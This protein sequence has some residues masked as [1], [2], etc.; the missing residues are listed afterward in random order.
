M[1]SV[2]R[3]VSGFALAGLFPLL[4]VAQTVPQPTAS[5][6][7][8]SVAPS[9]APVMKATWWV[10]NPDKTALL[11]EQTPISFS[12]ERPTQPSILVDTTQ[13]FQTMD[14]FGF[15]LTGGSA[16][17]IQGLEPSVRKALLEELFSTKG[18]GIG[19][20]YLRISIGSSDLDPA[21]FTYDD[22]PKGQTDPEL[23]QF[24][25][26]KDEQ[27]LIPLLHEVLAINPRIHIL[28]SP[29]SAPSWMKD[30]DTT[31]A[32]HLDPQWYKA[33][34]AYLVKYIKAMRARGIRVE[35]ITPQNEPLNPKNNP[36]MVMDDTAQD[37]FI[38]TALGPVFKASGLNTKVIVYD[39]NCDRPDYPLYILKDAKAAQYVAGSAFHLYLG[40]VEAM[41]GVHKAYPNKGLY[42]TEIYTAGGSAF[43][44]DLRWHIAN[45]II[46]APNNWAKNVLE[47]NLASDPDLNPHTPGG[48]NTCLGA[49]T[50]SDSVTVSRNVAYYIVA[51]ASKF[52]PSGSVRIGSEAP[53]DLVN[54]AFRMPSGKLVLI[55]LNNT[56][57]AKTFGIGMNGG[58]TA[59]ASLN[60]GAVGTFTW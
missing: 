10:T 18:K 2:S 16:I 15:A 27:Y 49:V 39:H 30:N 13:R 14:G 1:N 46:G 21:V 19:I 40:K 22:L 47:W 35:A 24:S 8:P 38:K 3:L 7:R 25:I 53:S 41:S 60:A 56:D 55:V 51:H 20:S 33:Y 36:S 43:R 26:Q 4:S 37:M 28:G 44:G 48:C 32:G 29:W 34:A 42:F 59:T 54:V 23:K 12:A 50:I 9:R 6:A 45:V 58:K 17:L 31:A 5:T 52:V 11:Q 57:Q